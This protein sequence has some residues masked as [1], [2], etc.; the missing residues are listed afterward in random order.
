M[1]E[2]IT[3]QTPTGPVRFPKGMSRADMAAALNSLPSAAP[4]APPSDIGRDP[5]DGMTPG[6]RARAAREGTLKQPS[7]AKLAAVAAFD[8][9]AENKMKNAPTQFGTFAANFAPGVTYG[10]ADEIAAGID[11][12]LTDRTYDQSVAMLRGRDREMAQA[13]PKTAIAGQVAGAVA[14]PLSTAFVPAKG[15]TMAGTVAN[16]ATA[17]ARAG[18]LYGFGTGEGGLDN[19]AA[20]AV[21]GGLGGAVLGAALPVV[22]AVA[23]K[24]VEKL[25]SP[26]G[27][28]DEIRLGL[29]KVL[30]DFG[31]PMTA[32]QRTGS[33]PLMYKEGATTGGRRIAGEQQEAF[34]TAVLKTAGIDAKRATP[35]VLDE[36]ATRIGNVFDNVTRN[37][38]VVPDPAALSALSRA[39]AEYKSLAPTGNQAPLVS[40]VLKAATNAFRG[41][42]TIPAVTV[43]TW[44]SGLSKL[45]TS[46]DAATRE[47][48]RMALETVDDMLTASLNAAGKMDDVARLATA[49]AEWRNLLAIQKAAVR[50]GDGLLS[51]ARVRA[52]VIQQGLSS[53]ARGKRGDLGDL[54]RAGGEVMEALPDSGTAQRWFSNVPGGAPGLL[55]AA[56]ASGASSAGLGTLGVLASG[57]AGAALPGISGAV[58]MSGPVQRYLGNQAGPALGRMAEGAMARVGSAMIPQGSGTVGETLMGRLLGR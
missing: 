30:D 23:R 51:P 39:V 44:R 2:F 56:A 6:E 13:Y 53:Y 14:S 12:T 33:K 8:N 43:N 24:G 52:N 16:S 20:S 41:G 31:V 10:F 27:G 7:D 35:E 38:D 15:A 32:G 11:A 42:N 21:Q 17:G 25:V 5:R 57:L 46:A 45:T 19:R 49:R 58:R 4:V 29:A 9:V 22:G 3:V 54:A 26:N 40:E 1:T 55:A 36:A 48:A 28:A 50:E 18:A 47:A 34:T 37:V